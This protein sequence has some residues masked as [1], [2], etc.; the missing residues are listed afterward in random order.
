LDEAEDSEDGE[1]ITN[2]LDIV[3]GIIA[4]K[5]LQTAPV[6]SEEEEWDIARLKVRLLVQMVAASDR[7]YG[8]AVLEEGRMGVRTIPDNHFKEERDRLAKELQ[9]RL[10]AYWAADD[11]FIKWPA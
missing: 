3:E 6:L 4:R 10:A 11:L 5:A 7:K 8:W 9:Q 1:A 2:G